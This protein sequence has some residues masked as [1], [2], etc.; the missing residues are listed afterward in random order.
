MI[1]VTTLD[2][3]LHDCRGFAGFTA[4]HTTMRLVDD[5]VQTV[6]LI[7]D[8]IS[9]RFPNGIGTAIAIFRELRCNR[10]LLRI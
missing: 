7:S 2:E 8:G 3:L 10:E 1:L 6:T 4:L 9:Q 5:K